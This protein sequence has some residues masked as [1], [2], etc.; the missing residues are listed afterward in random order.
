ML[1]RADR[2]LLAEMVA[3][4]IDSRL[5]GLEV[6]GECAGHPQLLCDR[7]RADVGMVEA[8]R[9]LAAGLGVDV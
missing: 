4:A 2:L 7:H 1:S 3:D 8:Y 5:A 9:A 6:C